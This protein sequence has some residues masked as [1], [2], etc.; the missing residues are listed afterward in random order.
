MSGNPQLYG[1]VPK[2]V[3]SPLNKLNEE[4]KE[5]LKQLRE[6]AAG[7]DLQPA[8]RK[9]CD[10]MCLFR[11]LSGLQ[12]DVEVSQKQLKDTLDWRASYKPQDIRL[13]DLRTVAESGWLYH[14]GFDKH[15]RPIIY[16]LMGKDKAENTEE[17]KL[18]KF[19]YFVYIMEKCVKRMPE[20]VY[21][22]TWIVDLK[23]SSLSMSVVKAM[24]DMFVKLG[25]YYTERLARCVVTNVGF[26]LN[27]IWAFVKPFLAQETVDKY[28]LVKGGDKEAFYNVAH[29]AQLPKEFFG[30]LDY[31]F[32]FNALVKDEE[33]SE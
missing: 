11:Y 4:Q 3:E 26:T 17:N 14:F 6:I 18:L 22:I 1:E 19:K 10:D 12:W 25:D 30:D 15:S 29:K 31:K 8:E 28:V 23:D 9:F 2:G 33:E 7:W 13:K 24:K 20:G 5:K 21:N 27:L 32:D 16:V